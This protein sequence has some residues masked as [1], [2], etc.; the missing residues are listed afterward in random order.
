M[1]HCHN[2]SGWSKRA[3]ARLLLLLL[4]FA[5]TTGCMKLESTMTLR[6]DGSGEIRE[7]VVVSAQMAAMMESMEQ[8]DS[9]ST[10]S[11]SM[12]SEEEVRESNAYPGAELKSVT[13]IDDMN[14][15]GYESVYTFSDIREVTFQ[16]DPNKIMSGKTDKKPDNNLS[17]MMDEMDIEFTPG[18]PAKLTIRMPQDDKESGDAEEDMPAD[19]DADTTAMDPQEMRMLQMMLRDA[20]FKMAIK[21]DGEIVE[22]NAS[23]VSDGEVTIMDMNFGEMVRDTTALK[24]F[25]QFSESETDDP[26]Q[27]SD[28]PGIK[29]ETQEEVSVLFK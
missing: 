24:T 10:S 21:I 18:A 7:R 8:M 16:R 12:F 11:G 13:M 1:S 20:A 9:S 26:A 17:G 23:H 28:L 15:K 25:A 22:T 3:G 29:I 5:V 19:T 14:G 27:I 2:V 6:P 4:A